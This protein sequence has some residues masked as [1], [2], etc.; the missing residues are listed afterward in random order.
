MRQYKK[1]LK[2]IGYDGMKL[3]F[4]KVWNFLTSGE[5]TTSSRRTL[6]HE[7]SYIEDIITLRVFM[8]ADRWIYANY[9]LLGQTRT[10]RGSQKD[11][12]DVDKD[13]ELTNL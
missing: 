1:D 5:V 6:L 12:S 11:I 2:E 4:P 10:P 8:A 3:W 13:N 9:K 7:M